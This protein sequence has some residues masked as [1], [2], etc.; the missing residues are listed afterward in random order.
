MNLLA[1]ID[2]DDQSIIWQIGTWP[3]RRSMQQYMEEVLMTLW[4]LAR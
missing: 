1:H 4:D 3:V 2:I